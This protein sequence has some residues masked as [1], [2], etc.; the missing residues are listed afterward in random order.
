LTTRIAAVVGVSIG[1]IVSFALL[2]LLWFGV[3]GILTVDGID[4]M[5]IFWPSSV[6]LTVGWRTTPHGI[7]MTFSSIAINCGIYGIL[8]ILT[9][10]GIAKMGALWNSD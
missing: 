10:T 1:L 3:A 7:F 4:L 5:R 8:A 9:R 2:T 6:M